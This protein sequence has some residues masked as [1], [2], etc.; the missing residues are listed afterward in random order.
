MIAGVVKHATETYISPN[1]V[2]QAIVN[3]FVRTGGMDTAIVTVKE[4]LRER[5][6]ALCTALERELPEARFV[7]PQGGYFMW[8]EL[9]RGTDIDA[10]YDAALGRGVQFVKGSDFVL[11]GADA[12]LRIAYSG[13]TP[14][15]IEE[16]VVRLAEAYREVSGAAV[17]ATA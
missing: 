1:M 10:L 2:A 4:A 7:Q 6:G 3:Q 14:A 15:Q 16:G 9:P 5:V 17:S 11:D 12:S 13:V 8:V